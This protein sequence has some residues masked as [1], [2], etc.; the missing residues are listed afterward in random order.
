VVVHAIAADGHQV[1]VKVAVPLSGGRGR[2]GVLYCHGGGYAFGDLD[3]HDSAIRAYAATTGM[4]VFGV[5]Y[6]RTPESAW[7]K[8]LED[9]LAVVAAM[10]TSDW[11]QDFGHD[12]AVIATIGDSAG[13]HLALTTM[14]ALRERGLPQLAAAGLFYG[15]YARRFDTWSHQTYGDGSHG[16]STARM[17]WFWQQLMGAE[18][19]RINPLEEPLHADL[20]GLPPLTLIAAE[21]DCLLNDT[22]D[23]AAR[24][25]AQ[26]HPHTFDLIKAVP[27]GFMH[28]ASVYE[29]TRRTLALLD[30]RFKAVL[31]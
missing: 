14:L 3:T 27:H 5:H 10:R 30:E 15:M 11:A 29:G 8:P 28:L 22:L 17:Q 25:R 13:A 24:C 2:P 7:P 18:T 12:P 9:A 31:D 26:K 16:L 23:L 1:A 6:R 19:G 21:V 20:T 4:V